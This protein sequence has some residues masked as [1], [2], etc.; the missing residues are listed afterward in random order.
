VL[1]LNE[2]P[3]YVRPVPAVVVAAEYTL[4]VP[5]I[6]SP[7]AE[8]EPSLKSPTI[9]DDELEKRPVENPTTVEVDT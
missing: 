4:F 7:P 2:L 9:V 1:T 6:A 5:S 3:E 8:S